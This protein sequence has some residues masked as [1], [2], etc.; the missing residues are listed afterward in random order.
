MHANPDAS[1]AFG[2]CIGMPAREGFTK[3]GPVAFAVMD[4]VL[5]RG[6]PFAR[7][8]RVDDTDWRLTVAPR[9]DPE[10]HETYGVTVYLR[11]KSDQPLSARPGGN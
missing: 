10:T 1:E 8:I 5:N 11:E 4:A 3:L 2:D 6:R 7:W 9:I